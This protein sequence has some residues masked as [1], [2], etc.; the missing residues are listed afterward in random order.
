M[1]DGRPKSPFAATRWSAVQRARR[2]SE[3]GRAALAELCEAYWEP[4]FRTLRRQGTSDD[5]AREATQAFFAW[6]LSG[7]RLAGADPEKG[8][9]RSYLLVFCR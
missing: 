7:G 5:D 2:D 1:T 8:R 9:F 6:I 3:Q 4:V